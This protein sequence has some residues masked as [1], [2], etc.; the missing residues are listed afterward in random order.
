MRKV[1]VS[2]MRERYAQTVLTF[3]ITYLRINAILVRVCANIVAIKK[4]EVLHAYSVYAFADLGTQNVIRMHRIIFSSAACLS[5]C[6]HS[7][8]NGK[9]FLTHY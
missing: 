7:L 2:R 6:P 3:L 5:N 1:T 4:I 8:K 9:V